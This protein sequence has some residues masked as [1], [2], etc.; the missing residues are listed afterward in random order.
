MTRPLARLLGLFLL[1]AVIGRYV[2]GLGAVRC[3]CSSE[4]W[5]KKPVLS[6]F[7]WVVPYGHVGSAEEKQ[8]LAEA[9]P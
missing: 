9:R 6:T 8:A 1:F 2:E 3:G 4:C 7:R 5:C